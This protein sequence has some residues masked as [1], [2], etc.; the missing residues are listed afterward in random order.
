MPPARR[1]PCAGLDADDD[2]DGIDL[3]LRL[4]IGGTDARKNPK[5]GPP[6]GAEES[7]MTKEAAGGIC[8]NWIIRSPEE[9][10]AEINP[11]APESWMRQSRARDRAGREDEAFS[12]ERPRRGIAGRGNAA[13][14]PR[15]APISSRKPKPNPNARP[16]PEMYPCHQVQYVSMPE[17]FGLACVTPCLG[18][19][20]SSVSSGLDRVDGNVYLL[21]ARSGCPNQARPKSS[22]N[23]GPAIGAAEG[24]NISFEMDSTGSSSSV[25]SNHHSASIKGG[26]ITSDD[27]RINTTS[28]QRAEKPTTPVPVEQGAKNLPSNNAKLPDR[29][30]SVNKPLTAVSKQRSLVPLVS[31]TGNGL[32]GRTINGFLHRYNDSDIKILCVCHGNSFTPAE[33]V[34]HAGGTNISQPLRQI[35]VT[36]HVV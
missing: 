14:S 32:N 6:R 9:A 24:G 16:C 17:R 33:F 12:G 15:D 8:E 22:S 30:D 34:R 4:A 31:T 11:A 27:S 23:G 20:V 5:P 3:D 35:V 7:R 26:S 13:P 28:S 1:N 19:V 2:G 25:I 10:S 21:V 36:S 29:A 18:K